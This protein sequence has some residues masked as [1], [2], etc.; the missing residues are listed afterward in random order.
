MHEKNTA[1]LNKT[2]A[3][4]MEYRE[5]MVKLSIERDMLKVETVAMQGGCFY[6]APSNAP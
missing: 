5:D 4:A 2:K 3:I 1:L 6:S